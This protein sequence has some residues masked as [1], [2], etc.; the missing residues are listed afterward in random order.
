MKIWIIRVLSLWD[1][2]VAYPLIKLIKKKYPDCQITLF[3]WGWISKD[4]F[5]RIEEI[6][7]VISLKWIWS[8]F[9]YK[10]KIILSN[11]KKYDLVIDTIQ[12]SKL[13]NIMARLFWKRCVWFKEFWKYSK[14]YEWYINDEDFV[15]L[16]D[17]APYIKSNENL[18]LS[19]K[20]PIYNKDINWL[21]S[22]IDIPQR[23]F[24]V[25]HPSSAKWFNS[26]KITI[27]QINS[28]V[29]YILKEK[30]F[31]ICLI[32]TKDDSEMI[33]NINNRKWLHKFHDK[34][35]TIRETWALISKSKLYIG[36][37]SGPMWISLALKKESIVINWP[38]SLSWIPPEEY[39]PWVHN[40]NTHYK[41]CPIPCEKKICIYNAKWVWKC[42]KNLDLNILYNEIDKILK[43]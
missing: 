26:K 35:L 10:F 19:L 29:D 12:G 42:M 17:L 15:I 1:S 21:K 13:T 11:F 41:K 7:N 6:D 28:I 5:Q 18:D 38:S 34:W 33:D 14:I 30:T 36:L 20:F 9:R 16:Q 37:N 3:A 39:Y 23:D 40:I 32:G 43:I 25:F 31:D 22:K 27:Q 4:Y 2:I 8:S 24:I